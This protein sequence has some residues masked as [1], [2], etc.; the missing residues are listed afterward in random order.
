MVLRLLRRRGIDKQV[1]K[2]YHSGRETD[3]IQM[4]SE[5]EVHCLPQ[6]TPMSAK[7]RV[8]RLI[9]QIHHAL[10]AIRRVYLGRYS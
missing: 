2:L 5:A 1:Q 6:L 10:L 3:L 4:S 7:R 9:L 8:D